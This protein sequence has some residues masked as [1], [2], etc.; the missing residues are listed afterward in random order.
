MTGLSRSR[1]NIT[2]SFENYSI[3]SQGTVAA[4][5][6]LSVFLGIHISAIQIYTTGCISELAD[7]CEDVVKKID[8]RVGGKEVSAAASSLSS[9]E[10]VPLTSTS[11]Q[12][13]ME[14][15][16][17]STLSVEYEDDVEEISEAELADALDPSRK[18]KIA[19][20]A[21]QVNQPLHAR[22][23]HH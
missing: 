23:P 11:K 20:T 19:I 9:S 4:A 5:S 18:R 13:G 7:F 1:I 10:T 3:D 15:P 17:T 14:Q 22:S 16:L 2:E 8:S 12:G 6:K 21:L